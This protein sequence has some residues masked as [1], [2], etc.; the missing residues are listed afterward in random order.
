MRRQNWQPSPDCGVQNDVGVK[1]DINY[2]PAPL[3]KYSRFWWFW[4]IRSDKMYFPTISASK[5]ND[6]TNYDHFVLTLVFFLLLVGG[7][8][9]FGCSTGATL[10]SNTMNLL[11]I[12]GWNKIYVQ[13][14]AQYCLRLT[15][16]FFIPTM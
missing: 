9:V 5:M 8:A 2:T 6:F 7:G 13:S 3:S 4:N 11:R 15:V 12:N 16:P 1:K 10:S 14:L